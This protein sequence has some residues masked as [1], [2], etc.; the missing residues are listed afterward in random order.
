MTA[1]K[2]IKSAADLV[3]YFH[4]LIGRVNET[5]TKPE[6]AAANDWL[7]RYGADLAVELVERSS[8]ADDIDSSTTLEKLRLAVHRSS[9]AARIDHQV[10][11]SMARDYEAIKQQKALLSVSQAKTQFVAD[12]IE[13][14]RITQSV[15]NETIQACKD[16]EDY[17]P[18]DELSNRMMGHYFRSMAETQLAEE[19]GFKPPKELDLP[20]E[21]VSQL[22]RGQQPLLPE[23]RPVERAKIVET[24][25]NDAV[26]PISKGGSVCVI[27]TIESYNIDVRNPQRSYLMFS[28]KQLPQENQPFKLYLGGKDVNYDGQKAFQGNHLDGRF[29]KHNPVGTQVILRSARAIKR[30][31]YRASNAFSMPANKT[32]VPGLVSL[33]TCETLS[34]EKTLALVWNSPS[35]PL[36]RMHELMKRFKQPQ[37]DIRTADPWVGFMVRAPKQD[38]SWH[39]SAVNVW[40]I[41]GNRTPTYV[42]LLEEAVRFRT[43]ASEDV[44][45][46]K[47]EVC[48]FDC[49]KLAPFCTPHAEHIDATDDQG[50]PIAVQGVLGLSKHQFFGVSV[51]NEYLPFP[52]E[53]SL[54]SVHSAIKEKTDQEQEPLTAGLT[55]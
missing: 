44:N 11:Q 39:S 17:A 36:H 48:L 38:G 47:A 25:L 6:L 43:K 8:K 16:A 18:S 21:P 3:K 42:D 20:D 54:L 15:F 23:D 34:D 40:K 32:F 29:A 37:T 51:V 7:V 13:S 46:S 35:T 4:G 26:V 22:H 24:Q 30:A 1:Q 28:S 27:G 55:R 31:S 53:G 9:I 52:S 2:D 10:E 49:V 19:H 14:G 50:Q 33:K 12:L 5:A 45:I 41:V